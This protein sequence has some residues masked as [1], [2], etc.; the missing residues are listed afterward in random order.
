MTAAALAALFLAAA[1]LLDRAFSPM[2]IEWRRKKGTTT[3]SDI[4]LR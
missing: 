4:P 2:E 1:A 3:R